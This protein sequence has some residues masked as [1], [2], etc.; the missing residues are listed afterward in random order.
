MGEELLLQTK[1]V[2]QEALVY[3]GSKGTVQGLCLV[4]LNH[5]I[6]WFKWGG[7]PIFSIIEKRCMYLSVPWSQVVEL[8]QAEQVLKHPFYKSGRDYLH[9]MQ[10]CLAPIVLASAKARSQEGIKWVLA[11][12][13][14]QW[15]FCCIS[16]WEFFLDLNF[17]LAEIKMWLRIGNT[18]MP[19]QRHFN[20]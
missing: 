9:L 15:E 4:F 1:A 17:W 12:K 11:R 5:L 13:V 19:F 3:S 7:N 16:F 2:W 18:H 8:A 10:R 6:T 14:P 20:Y